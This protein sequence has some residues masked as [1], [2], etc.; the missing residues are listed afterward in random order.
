MLQSLF[1][2]KLWEKLLC[3]V[4]L[5][6]YGKMS[7]VPPLNH[8]QNHNSCDCNLK[9]SSCVCKWSWVNIHLRLK[10][11]LTFLTQT[12]KHLRDKKFNI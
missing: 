9:Y 6:I 12:K 1:E 8:D 2:I 4:L 10:G 3:L 11:N 7:A 5:F